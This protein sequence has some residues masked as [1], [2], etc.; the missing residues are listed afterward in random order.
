MNS[1]RGRLAVAAVVALLAAGCGGGG[2]GAGAG[3]GGAGDKTE[4]SS[5]EAVVAAA[6]RHIAAGEFE[7][8]CA[9]VL[10]DA[11]GAFAAAGTDCQSFLARK[12]DQQEREAFRDVRVDTT[13][14]RRD[15]DTAVVPEAAV[16]FGGRPSHDD[17]TP[18]VRK[19]GKW[20]VT[21][22]S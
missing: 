7:Q 10:P 12:Y 18:T 2:G 5:P 20:W 16:T 22:G 1:L 11:R 17:D 4:Q 21:T 15:G 13:K 9:L 14:I 19:D 8:S 3:G 6:Y